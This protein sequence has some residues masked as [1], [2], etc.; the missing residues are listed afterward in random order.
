MNAI[1]MTYQ[2]NTPNIQEEEKNYILIGLTDVIE[3]IMDKDEIKARKAM[4][5]H[6][7]YSRTYLQIK[8]LMK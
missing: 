2:K 4:E 1:I 5:E 6:L 8:Q 3:A 7:Y